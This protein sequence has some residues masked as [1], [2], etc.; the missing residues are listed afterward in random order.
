MTLIFKERWQRNQVRRFSIRQSKSE[1]GWVKHCSVA[2]L[3]YQLSTAGF[4]MSCKLQLIALVSAS[5]S[6]LL[7]PMVNKPNTVKSK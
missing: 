3:C 5:L 1:V 4:E 2:D 6:Q 7:E